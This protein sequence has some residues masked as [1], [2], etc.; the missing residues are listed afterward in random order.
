[1]AYQFNN[2]S[3]IEPVSAADGILK[4]N[5]TIYNVITGCDATYSASNMTVDCSAG[6]ITFN[7]F[8]ITVAGG[9]SFW[10]LVSDSSNPRW[11]W[12][13]I[14]EN[15]DAVV[16]SGTAAA[17]PSV[18]ALGNRV[19]IALV[20]VEAGQTIAD[21]ITT[22]IDKRIPGPLSP[23]T[24]KYKTATQ[25]FTTSTTFA[26]ITASSGTFSF[27]AEANGIYVARYSLPVT[28]GGTGGVKLQLTGPASP[29]LVR[30]DS[31]YPSADGT[32]SGKIG[33]AHV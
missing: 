26:D 3:A 33:R 7:G 5:A 20:R 15:G 32:A 19:A 18:P 30:V 27:T 29:T 12:L 23:Y 14:D 13:A 6:S 22:K 11:T 31:L 21:N 2:V 24:Y 10:T 28:F 16:V 9:A 4:G 25:V 1:M 17:T 8:T